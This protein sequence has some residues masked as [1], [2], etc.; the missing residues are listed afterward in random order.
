MDHIL[1]RIKGAKIEDIKS[2]LRSDTQK[3]AEQGLLLKHIWHNLDEPEEILFIFTATDLNRAK[4]F[5]ETAHL[6]ARKE[7]PRIKLPEMTFLKSV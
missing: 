5:I 1:A 2:A 6:Q 3:H 7:N 4:K